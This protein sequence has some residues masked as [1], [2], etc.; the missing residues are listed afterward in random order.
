MLSSR[1][2]KLV[3]IQNEADGQWLDEAD[4]DDSDEE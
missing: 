3:L 2:V 4:E 1:C